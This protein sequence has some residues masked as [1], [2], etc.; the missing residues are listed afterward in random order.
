MG[1]PIKQPPFQNVAPGQTCTIPRLDMGDTC[2]ALLLKLSGKINGVTDFAVDHL[3]SIRTK[4][5]G[6]AVV[7]G[8]SGGEF[9]IINKFMDRHTSTTFL[10]IQFADN[11]ARTISGE[12]MG[13]IDTTL[14][15]S[16][17][18]MEVDI[19]AGDG[20]PALECWMVKS[21]PKP[22]GQT[23]ALFRAYTKSVE[24]FNAAATFSLAPALGSMAGNILPRLHIFTP[25]NRIDRLDVKK[26]GV[27][28]QGDG[29]K[30]VIEFLN[31]TTRTAQAGHICYDPCYSNNQSD[32]ITT[33][34]KNGTPSNIEFRAS[35]SAAETLT[36]V[37]ELYTVLNRI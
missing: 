19:A 10:M 28:I 6:K 17:F 37:A 9:Q 16:S 21:A 8:L 20:A 13:A 2:D 25:N 12:D 35:L 27:E 5:G 29:E 18:S 26:N 30:A 11:V 7:D 22:D 36:E 14:G 23:K 1:L 32:S 3:D 34:R 31:G 33:I 4:L 24:N 15:Y